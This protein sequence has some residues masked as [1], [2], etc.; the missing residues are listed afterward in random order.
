MTHRLYYDDSYNTAF[1]ATVV[2]VERR[3]PHQWVWLDRSLFYPTTGGQPFDT[4]TLDSFRVV[5][6]LDEEDD[7]VHVVA[8]GGLDVGTA[9]RGLIEWPRRFDHMQQH[10]GQHMLSAGFLKIMQAPTISVHFGTDVSTIDLTR[11]VGAAEVRA[12]EDEA[13]RVVWEDRTVVVR[14]AEADDAAVLGLR[15]P[16]DRRGTLRLVEI[17][18]CDLSACGG[19]HVSRTGAVGVIAVTGWERFKGGTRVEFACGGRVLRRHRD[20]RDVVSRSTRRLSVLPD[21]LAAAIERLQEEHR[22][23]RRRLTAQEHE[24]AGYRAAA[25][26]ARA[27][28]IGQALSLIE[29]VEGDASA[30]K[31]LAS[32]VVARPGYVAVLVSQTQPAALVVTRAPDVA[33][34]CQDV[35]RAMCGRFGG[36]GGGRPDLAQAGGL[37]GATDDMLDEARR[38]V[39][40]A[41]GV[42]PG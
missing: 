30:L 29:V 12:A 22:E 40:Q 34:A 42:R 13:N 38:L 26:A 24:L 10:T 25:A 41:L 16:S 3:G 17:E 28:P 36:K 6:V 9:V 1:D 15:K 35:L 39:T 14:Y 21:G 37:V 5:D 32:A 20:L 31:S 18:D 7:V 27:V 33:L 11:E 4:G 8:E 19:T 23:Q 2:R